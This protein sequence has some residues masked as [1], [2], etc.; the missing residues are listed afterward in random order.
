MIRLSIL[1]N[2]IFLYLSSQAQ[3][4]QL[5]HGDTINRRDKN[6]VK[7]GLWRRY[8]SNDTLLSES[9]FKDGM[10]TGSFKT[11]YKS[12][13]LQ[14]D[15]RFRPLTPNQI[16]LKTEVSDG[17]L[18]YENGK[19]EA[20]GKYI[21]RNKDSIW[22]YY[23]S[24]GILTAMENYIIGI[25]EGVWKVFYPPPGGKVS[26][27][28]TYKKGLKNGP[29]REYF[30]DGTKKTEAVM[31][32]DE[33]DGLVTMFYPNGNIQ[34]QGLYKNGSREGKWKVNKENGE[35]DHEDIF[36]NGNLMNPQPQKME[37]IEEK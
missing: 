11:Y 19:I 10:R 7:Q 26:Q 35:A 2:C 23:D 6:G 22:N 16:K 9:V 28:I 30:E 4:Y 29:Y 15:L 3:T 33:Y 5:F 25:K 13:K 14:S 1:I 32:N 36:K 31:K 20:K 24:D 12:G 34:M 17:V 8:Y 18:Y 37:K 27:E 21:D